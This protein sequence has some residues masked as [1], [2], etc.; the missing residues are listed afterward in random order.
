MNNAAYGKTQENL[1]K[2]YYDAIVKVEQTNICVLELS[3]LQMY[4]FDYEKVQKWFRKADLLM[5]DTKK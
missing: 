3:K 5:T 2:R 1:R 4:R